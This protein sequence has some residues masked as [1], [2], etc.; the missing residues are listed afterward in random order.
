MATS[1]SLYA[2][3]GEQ[4]LLLPGVL[5]FA[6]A[7]VLAWLM[8]QHGPIQHAAPETLKLP[9]GGRASMPPWRHAHAMQ[10]NSKDLGGR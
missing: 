1:L 2:A 9:D 8:T 6:H 7:N 4:C 3:N 10:G 5:P